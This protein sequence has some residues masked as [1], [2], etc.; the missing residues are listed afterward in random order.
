[1]DNYRPKV[2]TDLSFNPAES[3][4]QKFLVVQDTIGIIEEPLLITEFAGLLLSTMDGAHTVAEIQGYF[5]QAIAGDV[6]P[7]FVPKHIQELESLGLLDGEE[8]QE[9]KKA[10]VEGYL[11]TELRASS[12]SALAYESDPEKLHHWL[13]SVLQPG[14]DPTSQPGNLP[15]VVVA[16]HIDF[17][18]NTEAYGKAYRTLIGSHF[19]RV[20]LMGTGHSIAEGLYCPTTKD[21]ETPIG[22]TK[23]DRKSVDTLLSAG[24]GAVSPDDFPHRSEH[25][26][27]FQLIFLQ[28]VLGNDSFELVPILCGSVAHLTREVHRLSENHSAAK[29]IDALRGIVYEKDRETLV[30]AGVDFSHIGLRFSHQAPASELLEETR[31]HD[32]DLIDAFNAW[33]TESFWKMERETEGRFNVCG[34]ST[35]S[36][37]L[38]TLEPRDGRCLAYDVW[39]D[40][41]TGSAVTFA[42]LVA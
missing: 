34:F 29:F 5:D 25:A 39:D 13:D 17:R 8:Y 24:D 30:V 4:G 2:R 12:H 22:I 20:V 10:I 21:F 14:D 26:L 11:N 28:H 40:A 18:V 23:T 41:P 31:R 37:I 19:D 3:D 32:R 15:G 36:T 35:L 1:V 7:D 38:E 42:A 27:E 16:P 33:D 6:P 9:K